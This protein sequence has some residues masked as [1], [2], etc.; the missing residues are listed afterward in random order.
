MSKV[1]SKFFILVRKYKFVT[2]K[3]KGGV[4]CD[5]KKMKAF[6]FNTSKFKGR[7]IISFMIRRYIEGKKTP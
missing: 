3:I 7:N 2:K 6:I 4:T 5:F 1:T